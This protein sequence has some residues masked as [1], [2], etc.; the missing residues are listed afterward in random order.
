MNRPTCRRAFVRAPGAAAALV[1]CVAALVAPARAGF[2]LRDPA[3]R[4]SAEPL[5]QVDLATV[6]SSRSGVPAAVEDAWRKLPDR[7]RQAGRGGLTDPCEDDLRCRWL[8]ARREVLAAFSRADA[9]AR[10][11]AARGLHRLAD[12]LRA[13]ERCEMNDRQRAAWERDRRRAEIDDGLVQLALLADESAAEDAGAV[14]DPDDQ[15]LVDRL[16]ATAREKG[17]R[18]VAERDLV[19]ARARLATARAR[20]DWL[21][22][23]PGIAAMRRLLLA[24]WKPVG[25]VPRGCGEALFAPGRLSDQWRGW[26]V[27]EEIPRALDCL[28]TRLPR[29]LSRR[30]LAPARPA[31][32]AE[33]RRLADEA[34]RDAGGRR[35]GTDPGIVDRIAALTGAAEAVP[36]RATARR[37]TPRSAP[38]RRKAASSAASR[39]AA[40]AA[41]SR[42]PAAARRETT[43]PR[44]APR[45]SRARGRADAE[46]VDLAERVAALTGDARL[47]RRVRDARTTAEKDRELDALVVALHR[48]ACAPLEQLDPRDLRAARQAL[49]GPAI[50]AAERAC[51]AVEG[52]D[53]LRRLLAVAP[54]LARLR[55]AATVRQAAREAALGRTRGAARLLETVDEDYRGLAWI[56]VR[57]WVARVEGDHVLAARLM[58][59]L[60]GPT[61]SRL[62][63]AGAEP[64]ARLVAHAWA[65][66]RPAGGK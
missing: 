55:W 36:A 4:Q 32:L 29:E 53:G 18:A 30:G 19:A 12:A 34:R 24:A 3:D 39:P 11:A 7:C 46:L 42:R 1:L 49:A 58:A 14:L 50:D 21:A 10:V 8:A 43:P 9:G 63:A 20:R 25:K 47:V 16:V 22:A 59:R 61:L 51:R 52:R 40:S 28:A 15:A 45:P 6:L 44:P 38:P 57:A 54:H 60:D 23:Q 64:L 13:G 17:L 27:R 2:G 48:H 37:T 33:A 35:F 62:R 5:R 66:P 65:T 26:L 31:A 56:V 41:P